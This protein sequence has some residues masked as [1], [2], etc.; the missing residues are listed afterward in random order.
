M[1]I[2]LLSFGVEFIWMQ[3][4]NGYQQVSPAVALFDFTS[5]ER[6]AFVV[7]FTIRGTGEGVTWD[8]PKTILPY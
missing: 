3:P 5:R 7:V 4:R 8:L 1:D 6:A 2:S